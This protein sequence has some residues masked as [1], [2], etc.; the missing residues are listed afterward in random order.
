MVMRVLDGGSQDQEAFDPCGLREASVAAYEVQGGRIPHC[1]RQGGGKLQGIR[2]AQRV[3]P[4]QPERLL[5]QVWGGTDV[6]PTRGKSREF[7]QRLMERR[8]VEAAFPVAAVQGRRTLD[9]TPP[10]GDNAAV[11]RQQS[12]AMLARRLVDQQ[13][14]Q[15]R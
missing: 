14:H 3:R 15:G 5:S 9:P 13:R 8:A 10:P 2:G 12:A 4:Q 11:C 7:L 1:S 6:Q